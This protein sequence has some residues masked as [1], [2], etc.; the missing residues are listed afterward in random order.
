[1]CVLEE[2]GEHLASLASSFSTFFLEVRGTTCRIAE[3]FPSIRRK[4]YDDLQ[5]SLLW[6]LSIDS[7][8]PPILPSPSTRRNERFF[9]LCSLPPQSYLIL[10]FQLR[11]PFCQEGVA[12]FSSK[13]SS[14]L[15]H[16]VKYPIKSMYRTLSQNTQTS[17]NKLHLVVGFNRITIQ[18]EPRRHIPY[19]NLV[20]GQRSR[21]WKQVEQSFF[22]VI[23]KNGK[24]IH[25]C[26][27]L[28]IH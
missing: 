28:S 24:T 26:I 27:H 9:A 16:S 2:W 22:N 5:V 21:R 10:S 13:H 3:S 25:V 18:P 20:S 8:L 4:H 11:T 6:W 19:P 17:E 1:M 7:Y 23:I 14:L 15:R 12:V